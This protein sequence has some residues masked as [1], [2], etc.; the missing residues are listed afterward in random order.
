MPTAALATTGSVLT[1]T[2]YNYLPRGLVASVVST[3]SNQTGVTSAVDLTGMTTTATYTNGRNY[4]VLA[5]ISFSGTVAGD[6]LALN[7]NIGAS[8]VYTVYQG[9]TGTAEVQT[10][11]AMY[12]ASNLS[13][14]TVI[15]L[16]GGRSTGTGTITFWHSRRSSLQ[17]Y[18]MGVA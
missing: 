12:Y 6:Y 15:K 10:V 17:I 8:N 7:V 3:G 9:Y 14:S 4:L 16:N 18:D 13:G 5:Q 1:A 11:T 2:E